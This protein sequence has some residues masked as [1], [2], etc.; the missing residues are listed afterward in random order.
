MSEQNITKQSNVDYEEHCRNI[1]GAIAIY[2]ATIE[3]ESD[4]FSLIS[5]SDDGFDGLNDGLNDGLKL[6]SQA[7][8]IISL[9]RSNPTINVDDIAQAIG[10]NKPTAERK[11]SSLRKYRIIDRDGSKESV[12]WITIAKATTK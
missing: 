5:K 4:P 11:I 12:R 7:V 2:K 6:T 10:V 3:S 1:E 8:Q 9:M